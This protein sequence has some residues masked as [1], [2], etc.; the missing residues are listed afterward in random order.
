MT[1]GEGRELIRR[2]NEV[3]T[4]MRK[5]VT[6]A[7]MTVLMA[8]ATSAMAQGP[9]LTGRIGAFDKGGIASSQ[10]AAD[11]KPT[12]KPADKYVCPMGCAGSESDKPGN[13]PKCGMK[14][15]KAPAEVN[16]QHQH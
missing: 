3:E 10:L 6:M 15:K 9:D 8:G 13:C 5:Y 4:I 14:L 7:A 11:D 12:T 16:H 1:Q 2:T